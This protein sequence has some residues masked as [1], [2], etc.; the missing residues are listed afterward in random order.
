MGCQQPPMF[1]YL[2]EQTRM[3]PRLIYWTS[4][5]SFVIWMMLYLI[6]K[7][8]TDIYFSIIQCPRC[9]HNTKASHET[10][11]R[12]VYQYIQGTKDKGLI[13][14]PPKKNDGGLLC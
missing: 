12:R 6:S 11:V 2:L 8:I 1:R 3:V 10:A 9:T 14:N 7:K 5:H 4:S 13:Y